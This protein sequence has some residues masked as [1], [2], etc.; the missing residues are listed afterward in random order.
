M[1]RE[2]ESVCRWWYACYIHMCLEVEL[3]SIYDVRRENL[4][5][6]VVMVCSV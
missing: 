1:N 3:K 6:K 5:W 2:I 4:D